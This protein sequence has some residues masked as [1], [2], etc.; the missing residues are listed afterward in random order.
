MIQKEACVLW[1]QRDL[2]SAN[3]HR[4]DQNVHNEII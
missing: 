4:L 3:E 1:S 2:C